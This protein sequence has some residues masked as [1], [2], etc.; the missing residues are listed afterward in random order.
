MPEWTTIIAGA[1]VAILGM[2]IVALL[3]F[4]RHPV[5]FMARQERRRLA[6]LGFKKSILDT[7]SG[8]LVFW[9]AGSGPILV[10]LHGAG[11]QAGTWSRVLPQLGK[12]R[13]CL[14]IDF[15]GHGESEPRQGPLTMGLELASLEALLEARVA[16]DDVVVL[17]GNSM[18]AW[19]A[20]LYAHRHPERVALLIAV[21]GGALNWIRKE[22]SLMPANRDEARH[23]LLLTRGPS[24]PSVPGFVLD[25]IVRESHRGPIGRLSQNPGDLRQYFMEDRLS[26]ITVPVEIVWGEDD[27]LL[28][29]DYAKR[30]AD[31]IPKARLTL[32]PH[33]GHI[34]QRHCPSAFTATVAEIL[35]SRIPAAGTQAS[36]A[37]E[38]T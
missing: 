7:S 4:W 21:N 11:D 13:R 24:S 25:D 27:R 14:L 17:I 38:A 31:A 6:R 22:V 26:E 33:C 18:G 8:K 3:R 34:P 15:A 36:S 10:F 29:S 32:L 28:G 37:N 5:A 19:V 20:M 16:A 2:V 35:K 9:E 1:L 23:L 12:G 30:L